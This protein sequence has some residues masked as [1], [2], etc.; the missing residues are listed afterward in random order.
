MSALPRVVIVG[1]MNVGKSTLF[2]RLSTEVKSLTMDYAGVTRDFIKDTVQWRGALFEL[3]D[4][5]GIALRRTQ[6]IIA[7]HVEAQVRTLIEESDVVL[8]VCDGTV[9]LLPEEQRLARFLHELKKQV[10]V[11]INKADAKLTQEHAYEFDRLGFQP[12]IQIS[13]QH[14]TGVGDVLDAA[15]DRLP[16]R[17]FTVVEGEDETCTAVLL[18]KPNVGKSSL[19]NALL[20]QERSIVTEQAGTTREPI[21]EKIR[22]YQ[23]D[24]QLVDTAGL[25][26]K[27]SVESG[28]ETLM[29][30]STLQALREAHIV[31]LLIDAAEAKIAD[32]ELKLAFYAFEQGKALVVLFNKQDLMTDEKT[33]DLERSVSEY[34]YFVKNLETL[35]ISCK[36]EKNVGKIVPLIDTV[37]KRY[38]YRFTNEELKGLFIKA[39]ES[40][41]LY[42]KKNP[43]IVYSVRQIKTA[44]ITIL[45]GVN[46]PGWF[47]VSQCKFFENV[48]R[49]HA[50]LRGVPVLFQVKKGR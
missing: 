32:Q 16:E 48:L 41:P 44:P 18:G 27:R 22:F 3:V 38:S 50:D 23:E 35:S 8:F 2:N 46:E 7:Q 4:S 36:T 15:V 6:D 24:I 49:E 10:V 5:G 29:A 34:T 37:W 47:G 13:A 39:L 20:K 9:G 28:I 42:H 21:R 45:L 40:R 17:A 33:I 11:V 26:R 1:R 31:L 19:M 12:I 43:L 30:K 14:G 25:R